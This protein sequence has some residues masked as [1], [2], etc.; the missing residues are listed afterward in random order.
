MRKFKPTVLPLVLFFLLGGAVLRA[1]NE[2]AALPAPAST[3]ETSGLPPLIQQRCGACHQPPRPGAATLDAWKEILPSMETFMRQRNLLPSPPELGAIANYYFRNSPVRFPP[4]PDDLEPSGIKLVRTPVGREFGE[5]P[6]IIGHVNVTDLDQDGRQE[7]VVC[8]AEGNQVT[9]LRF[10]DNEWT[11]TTLAELTAPVRSAVIDFNHDGHLDLAIACIGHVVPSEDLVGEA[12]LLLN[13]G[14][15]TFEKIPLLRGLP[16]ISD[17]QPGDLDGDGDLDFAVGV[18]GWRASGGLGWLEQTE[19]MKFH[20]HP[21]FAITGV[22]HLAVADLDGDSTP[23]IVAL[24]SQE[25]EAIAAFRCQGGGVFTH[26]VLA[27]ANHPLFGSSGFSLVDLDQDGDLDM[28]YTNGDMMDIKPEVKPYHGLR[29]L[30][31][32]GGNFDLRPIAPI[33]GCYSAR[34]HD[35]DGDGD[36]DI[37]ASNMNFQW[38][39]SDFPSLLWLENDG[40]QHFTRRRIDYAPV[41]LVTCDVGDLNHDGLPDIVAG[42]MHLPGLFER[43][44]RVTVWLQK[45]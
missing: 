4:I 10:Q 3:A 38:N 8:D 31:N 41:N 5:E 36:L 29:W 9:W 28:L 32:R 34:A 22:M 20:Y 30:E 24:I 42:S 15:Q 33:P 18:F 2:T 25:H 23:E 7:T 45:K 12:H 13:R 11:E 1:G 14:D 6:P 44:G 39:I 43:M 37:V 17:L 27:R 21:I 19:P 16:R 26:R 40:Q 35:M